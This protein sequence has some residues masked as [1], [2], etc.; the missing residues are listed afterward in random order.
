MR[1]IK[2]KNQEMF[3]HFGHL[4]P[5]YNVKCSFHEFLYINLNLKPKIVIIKI[6]Y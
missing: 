2:I 3:Q 5:E 1:L 4:F 6:I